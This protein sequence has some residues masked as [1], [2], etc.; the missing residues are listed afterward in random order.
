MKNLLLPL[1]LALSG[2]GSPN[3]THNDSA[4]VAG[5]HREHSPPFSSQERDIIVAAQRHIS[6]SGKKP[7]GALNDAFYRVRANADGYEVFV[8][9]VTG[10]DGP[11]PLFTPCMHNEVFLGPDGS[12]LKV[13]TGPECWPSR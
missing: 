12:L 8:I 2:C 6:Q 7:D 9:Y 4:P 1:V 11:K 5:F 10:Y 3:G 13:L